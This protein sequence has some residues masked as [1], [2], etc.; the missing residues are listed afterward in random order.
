MHVCVVDVLANESYL[1]LSI[2]CY[3]LV[4]FGDDRV[5]FC[6]NPTR[7]RFD[8]LCAAAEVNFVTVIVRWVMTRGDYDAGICPEITNRK[9]KFRH[10]SRP[11]EYKC[12]ATVFGCNFA[13]KLSELLREKSRI[14]RNHNCGFC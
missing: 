12:V 2:F 7:V 1:A 9:R 11:V 10:G 6:N 13:G 14:M 8:Y 3:W 5:H 4:R